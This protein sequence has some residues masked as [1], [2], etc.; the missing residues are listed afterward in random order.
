MA[1]TIPLSAIAQVIVFFSLVGIWVVWVALWRKLVGALLDLGVSATLIGV[2]RSD[3][4]PAHLLAIVI[5]GASFTAF[6]VVAFLIIRSQ[7]RGG[8][9]RRQQ[10]RY[11]AGQAGRQAAARSAANWRERTDEWDEDER[12]EWP[13]EPKESRRPTTRRPAGAQNGGQRQGQ[14]HSADTRA[15]QGQGY[16][17]NPRKATN[18]ARGARLQQ[19]GQGYVR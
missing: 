5:V 17:V 14:R 9:V 18:P 1:I 2:S 11:A 16:V 13:I 12:D 4:E 10:L 6:L 19:G 7:L 8:Q 3:F 15:R